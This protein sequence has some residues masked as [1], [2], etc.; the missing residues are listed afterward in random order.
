MANVAKKPRKSKYM[1]EGGNAYVFGLGGDGT[2][3][4][5]PVR[6]ASRETEPG[7]NAPF[8]WEGF[9]GPGCVSKRGIG[10][11]SEAHGFEYRPRPMTPGGHSPGGPKARFSPPAIWVPYIYRHFRILQNIKIKSQKTNANSRP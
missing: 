3:S 9:S 11:A 8:G 6:D 10:P 4:D 7:P 2:P 5:V 1:R